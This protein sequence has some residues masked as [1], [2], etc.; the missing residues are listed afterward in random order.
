MEV[1]LNVKRIVSKVITQN[2]RVLRTRASK[3]CEARTESESSAPGASW[4]SASACAGDAAGFPGLA[5]G[6]PGKPACPECGKL[7]SNNSNLKQHILNVHAARDLSHSCPVCGK[8][9]K[10][11]Q[12]MQIHMNSIHGVKQR[13]RDPASSTPCAPSAELDR[14]THSSA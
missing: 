14:Y 9:F 8:G 12:Y 3:V 2:W 7:Y 1:M 4:A 5:N 10:T 13:R 11:R 6:E